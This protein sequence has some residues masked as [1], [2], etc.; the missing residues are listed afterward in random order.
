MKTELGFSSA[1]DRRSSASCL[2]PADISTNTPS[3]ASTRASPRVPGSDRVLAEANGLSRQ[4]SRIRIATLAPRWRIEF[5]DPVDGKR[6]IANEILLV[7]L[8]RRRVDR[9]EIVRPA[10]FEAVTGV[11]E[12]RPVAGLHVGRK[13]HQRPAHRPLVDILNPAHDEAQALEFARY[14]ARV[15]HRLLQPRHIGV[16]IVADDQGEI[17]RRL[18]GCQGDREKGKG[19][20]GEQSAHLGLLIRGSRATSEPSSFHRRSQA[21]VTRFTRRRSPVL[22]KTASSSP[23]NARPRCGSGRFRRS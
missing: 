8:D 20:Q 13:R 4:A 18:G 22:A 11:K 1:S 23:H 7:R 2:A 9:Q 21:R 12:Q 14:G 3:G 17:T 16:G 10:D 6:R 15:I 5:D 19:Q